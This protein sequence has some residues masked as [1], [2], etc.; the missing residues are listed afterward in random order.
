MPQNLVKP[1]VENL[2]KRLWNEYRKSEPSAYAS[3]DK[4]TDGGAT[5]R[6]FFCV[7]RSVLRMIN[8]KQIRAN[9]K[10]KSKKIKVLSGIKALIRWRRDDLRKNHDDDLICGV[11]CTFAKWNAYSNLLIPEK[12]REALRVFQG[13]S[14]DEQLDTVKITL[15]ED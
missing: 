5:Q 7:A 14:E 11:A 6:G 12:H 4:I 1:T 2:A 9:S 8:S 13:L 3:W 10:S 15:G